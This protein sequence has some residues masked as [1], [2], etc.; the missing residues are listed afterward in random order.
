M[1]CQRL[2]MAKINQ[3]HID[4]SSAPTLPQSVPWL[5]RRG[6]VID[7]IGP[8]TSSY[9]WLLCLASRFVGEYTGNDA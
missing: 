8:L 2:K 3:N 9:K 6:G 5:V 4:P 1:M 7:V